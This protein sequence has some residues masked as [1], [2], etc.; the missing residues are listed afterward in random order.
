MFACRFILAKSESSIMKESN[1][2]NCVPSE[3][4]PLPLRIRGLVPHQAK[5]STDNDLPHA[6]CQNHGKDKDRRYDHNCGMPDSHC[7]LEPI[8]PAQQDLPRARVPLRASVAWRINAPP[9]SRR[10]VMYTQVPYDSQALINRA[11][12]SSQEGPHSSCRMSCEYCAAAS[13]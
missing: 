8:Y 10:P 1:P 12:V 5:Y 9:S 11:V 13:S 2:S 6:H 4:L 7:S 3:H